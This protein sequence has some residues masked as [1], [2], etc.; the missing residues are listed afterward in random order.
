MS[1]EEIVQKLGE[2]TILKIYNDGLSKPTKE[3]GKLF[4]T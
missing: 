3:T 4:R 2:D 1:P